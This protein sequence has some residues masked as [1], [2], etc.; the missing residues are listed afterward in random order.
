MS[1]SAAFSAA[2]LLDDE[3]RDREP[4]RERER[5][6]GVADLRLRENAVG[7]LTD[8]AGGTATELLSWVSSLSV[9]C[10]FICCH[11]IHTRQTTAIQFQLQFISMM[12]S[13]PEQHNTIN[14]I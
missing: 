3:D 2:A 4:D 13:Q 9:T 1:A 8:S 5:D 14:F 6:R 12:G 11:H 7:A 10:R